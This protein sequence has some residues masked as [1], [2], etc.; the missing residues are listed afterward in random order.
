MNEVLEYIEQDTNDKI[1]RLEVEMS[2]LEP[3]DC[4]VTHH[5]IPHFYCRQIFMPKNTLVTSLIHN[6]FHPYVVSKGVVSVFTDEQQELLID[7]TEKPFSSITTPA[8]RRVLFCHTDVIWTTF[9]P[10]EII[11]V[12]D[13]KEAIDNAVNEIMNEIIE[14]RENKYLGGFLKNNKII[15]TVENF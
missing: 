4:P 3:V 11:P 6:T 7:A 15:K 14:V 10:T 9:H 8:T 13:S 12:D 2:K 1:D 5:F